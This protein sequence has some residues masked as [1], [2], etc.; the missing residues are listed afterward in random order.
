MF[1]IYVWNPFKGMY[2]GTP[3][4][5]TKRVKDYLLQATVNYSTNPILAIP[6]FGCHQAY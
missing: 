2:V 1:K 4:I 6:F 5:V 3:G